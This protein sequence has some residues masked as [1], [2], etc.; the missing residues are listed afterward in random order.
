MPIRCGGLQS[1]RDLVVGDYDGVTLIPRDK[2]ETVLEAAEN[3]LAYEEQRQIS[4]D[5]YERCRMAGE[6][7][8]QLAPSWVVKMMQGQV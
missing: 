5:E 7:L 3:K 1:I 2:I 4:I 8:P 6:P